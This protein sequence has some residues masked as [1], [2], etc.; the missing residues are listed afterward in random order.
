VNEDESVQWF[1]QERME[2]FLEYFLRIF[3]T[4]LS[5]DSQILIKDAFA[6][7][8]YKLEKFLDSLSPS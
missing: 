5:D 8:E 1:N 3:G 4:E 2:T 7:S 6:S